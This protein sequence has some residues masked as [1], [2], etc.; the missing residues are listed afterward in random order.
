M[1]DSGRSG[2]LFQRQRFSS[3]NPGSPCPFAIMRGFS[4]GGFFEGY[5]GTL[6]EAALE[7]LLYLERA[8]YTR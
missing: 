8:R 2:G 7:V 5:V 4:S 3:S 1:A 6:D